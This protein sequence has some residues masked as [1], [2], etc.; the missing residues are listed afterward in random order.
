MING[1]LH[2]KQSLNPDLNGMGRE[3]VEVKKSVHGE[4]PR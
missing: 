4:V 1:Y 2:P 3:S